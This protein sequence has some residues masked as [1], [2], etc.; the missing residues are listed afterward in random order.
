[1]DITKIKIKIGDHE[2]AAEGPVDTVKAQFETFKELISLQSRQN[3]TPKSG[4]IQQNQ[5]N[6]MVPGSHAHV[7]LDKILHADGRVISLTALPTSTQDAALIIMLGHKEMRN[8]E[9][10][11]AQEIGDGLKQSGRQILRVDRIM[12]EPISD[13]LV[14]KSGVKRST[15]YRLTNQ[16]KIRALSVAR[17][18]IATLP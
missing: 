6:Q 11:T 8:S 9:S 1:M 3:V 7:P 15:R 17:E 12:D 16:G 13:S 18:L 10:V 2:F 4:G 5:Q 14:M